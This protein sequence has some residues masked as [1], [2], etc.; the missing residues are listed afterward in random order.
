[1]KLASTTRVTQNNNNNIE[2]GKEEAARLQSE[3]IQAYNQS[4]Y[5]V[6]ERKFSDCLKILQTIYY[7]E[8]PD[9]LK[10]ENSIRLV[11]RKKY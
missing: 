8:H 10:V 3:G 1:M 6:A 7:P 2:V 5:T 11:Q 4:N 9:C